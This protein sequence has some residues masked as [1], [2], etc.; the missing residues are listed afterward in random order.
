MRVL[1]DFKEDEKSHP[2][3]ECVL[4]LPRPTDNP[5]QLYLNRELRLLVKSANYR[6]ISEYLLPANDSNFYFS[7][8]RLQEI[9]YELEQSLVPL[10]IIAG[11]HLSPKQHINLEQMF[12]YPIWDKFELVLEIFEDRAMTE[13]SKLQIELAALRY[14]SPRERVRLMH[15]L[16]LE[17]AWHTERSGFWST[18]ENP[19][20]VLDAAVAKKEAL[21]RKRL[22]SLKM[23]RETRR[24]LRKRFHQDSLYCC[25]VGYTSAGKSTILN[26][27]T[28][29]TVSVGSRLFETLDTRVRSFHLDDLK[30]FVSDTIG[31][32]E[33]LPT[34]L[35]DSFKSTLE[36]GLAADLLIMVIDV[37]DSPAVVQR[38]AQLIDNTLKEIYPENKRIVV[39]NKID[40]LE[41]SSERSQLKNRI[42]ILQ[43]EFPGIQIVPLSAT[44]D[45]KPL[46]EAIGHFRPKNL[47]RCKF[48]PHPKFRAFCHET[49]NV[50]KEL[51]FPK[52][53]IIELSIR[54]PNKGIAQIQKKSKTLGI[55]LH[56]EE[57]SQV[58]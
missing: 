24:G 4:F 18:G 49:V 20:N 55:E 38:K 11:V 28:G 3:G 46:V 50:Q 45:I 25:L 51:F 29:S 35:I 5:H 37:S 53:W 17:G 36:E 57:I 34:F 22:V 47:Y 43:A 2:K 42:K 21:L 41:D 30:I 40:L 58:R 48:P 12:P 10:N 16:G 14:E 26:Q 39:L 8:F 19:L 56:I 27:L 31:F 44:R 7:N 54:N 33:D 6:V 52:E 23:Q 13:E 1:H 32:L 9:K 15:Q